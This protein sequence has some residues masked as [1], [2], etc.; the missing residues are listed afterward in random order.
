MSGDVKRTFVAVY[1][2]KDFFYPPTLV[3]AP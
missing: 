1:F 2:K 3:L